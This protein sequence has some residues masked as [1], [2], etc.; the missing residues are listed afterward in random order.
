M[1][2]II[3]RYALGELVNHAI[4]CMAHNAGKTHKRGNGGTDK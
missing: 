2:I 3:M 1:I 4:N